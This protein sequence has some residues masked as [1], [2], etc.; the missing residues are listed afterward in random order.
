MDCAVSWACASAKHAKDSV[1]VWFGPPHYHYHCQYT[2]SMSEHLLQQSQDQP[3][4]PRKC[5]GRV[6][7]RRIK[8]GPSNAWFCIMSYV[9]RDERTGEAHWHRHEF[10]HVLCSPAIYFRETFQVEGIR[11]VVLMKH[12]PIHRSQNW[13][14]ISPQ[15]AQKVLFRAWVSLTRRAVAQKL[16]LEKKHL[17]SDIVDI[18]LKKSDLSPPYHPFMFTNR[19]YQMPS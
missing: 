3:L 10:P 17:P 5:L 15:Y 19:C 14:L 6:K 18:I 4:S 9:R 16:L 8:D 13:S 1:I 2:N 12:D 7:C 11:R